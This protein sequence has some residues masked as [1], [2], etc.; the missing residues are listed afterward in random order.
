MGARM[1]VVT[2]EHVATRPGACPRTRLFTSNHHIPLRRTKSHPYLVSLSIYHSP[3]VMSYKLLFNIYTKVCAPLTSITDHTWRY[4]TGETLPWNFCYLS[5]SEMLD[6]KY[7]ATPTASLAANSLVAGAALGSIVP[8]AITLLGL[9]TLFSSVL[10]FVGRVDKVR[11]I[12]PF[13]YNPAL[14]FYPGAPP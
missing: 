7:P 9:L 12:P 8:A 10:V 1:R 5:P 14:T 11:L 2:C 6:S 4:A 13:F 3:P